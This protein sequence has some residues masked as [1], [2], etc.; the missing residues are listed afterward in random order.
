MRVD[1]FVDSTAIDELRLLGIVYELRDGP[2]L[3]AFH[4]VIDDEQRDQKPLPTTDRAVSQ[5]G[6]ARCHHRTREVDAAGGAT[7]E[8]AAIAVETVWAKLDRRACDR[9]QIALGRVGVADDTNAPRPAVPRQLGRVDAQ[10]A[11]LH[12]AAAERIAVSDARVIAEHGGGGLY[13]HGRS[14]EG[15]C[16]PAGRLW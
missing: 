4:S 12:P 9:S 7:R 13:R 11:H 2:V 1:P 8:R 5:L 6:M 15:L 3:D 16:E 10:R 14:P